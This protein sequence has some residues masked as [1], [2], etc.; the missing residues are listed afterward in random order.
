MK[1]TITEIDKIT[2]NEENPSSASPSRRD[3]LKTAGAVAPLALLGDVWRPRQAWAQAPENVQ[4]GTSLKASISGS[5]LTFDPNYMELYEELATG[6]LIYNRLVRLDPDMSAHPELALSWE[7]NADA[8]VWTFKLRQGVK[9][10]NGREFTA[11]DVAAYFTRVADPKS[12]SAVVSELSPIAGAE[13]VDKYT[14]RLLLDGGYADCPI[15]VGKP[16]ASIIAPESA[17]KDTGMPIG[18]GPYKF[19]QFVPGERI[20]VEANK[21]YFE[22]GQ[23]YFDEV[24]LIVYPDP[25]GATSALLAGDVDMRWEIEQ[26]YIDLLSGDPD[27]TVQRTASGGY[28]DMIMDMRVKPFND[29]RVVEAIKYCVDREAFVKGVLD[30]YGVVGNDH[31]VSPM[32]PFYANLP[33]RQRD[34]KRAKD[35]LALAG[36]PDGLDIDVHTSEIR[37]GM[38]PSAITMKDQC[39]PAGIRFNVKVEPADGYWKEI[40]RKKPCHYSNWGMR[41]LIHD[42]F[43]PFVT[44]TGKWNESG[45][46]NQTVDNMIRTAMSETDQAQRHK[47]YAA[48]QALVMHNAGLLIPYF[49]DYIMATRSDIKGWPMFATKWLFF[50][51]PYRVKT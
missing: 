7:P 28:Q 29:P 36:Y 42:S 40:W 47:Y 18:T 33:I 15:V 35:L 26:E 12:G 37:A 1:E 21:D 24:S 22:K 34:Y 16:R 44:T 17:G 46:S 41:P 49:K 39:A 27:V 10:H 23:P 45:F 5:P 11:E 32:D 6:S 50:N 25:A 14:V 43:N 48:T 3:F 8:S 2:N 13:V 20:V 51:R 9:F 19:K 38:V 4:Y 30:G 31:A